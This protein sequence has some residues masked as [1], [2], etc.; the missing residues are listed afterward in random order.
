MVL[1][2]LII[3]SVSIPGD[4]PMTL[5]SYK[6]ILGMMCSVVMW[7]LIEFSDWSVRDSM[8]KVANIKLAT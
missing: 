5:Y 2:S 4:Q 3:I 7:V 1:F 6:C 8:P